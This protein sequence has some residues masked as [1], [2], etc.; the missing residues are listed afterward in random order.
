MLRMAGGKESRGIDPHDDEARME[1][2]GIDLCPMY[3]LKGRR[4]LQNEKSRKERW[5]TY[6][7]GKGDPISTS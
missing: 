1:R 5:E 2:G 4:G 6:E 3:K 7:T